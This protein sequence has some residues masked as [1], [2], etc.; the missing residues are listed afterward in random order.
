MS[1]P[2]V[3]TRRFL[4]VWQRNFSV[5]RKT[6][7]ISFVPPLLEPLLY[8]AAFG[9]GLGV[10]VGAVP[11]RGGSVDYLTFIAPGLL[12]VTVMQNAFFE[13]TYASFVR[14]Y[15]QKTFDGMLATPLVLEEVIL[16][17]LAWAATKSLLATTLM[18]AVIA[19][20]G[21]VAF[22]AA[23]LVLPLALLGGVVF[24]AAGML[25][26]A[27]VPNIETFNLP[28]FLFI[29]PMFLFSGTFF[30]VGNLPEWA[31]LLALALPLT[32]LVTLARAATFGFY[33]PHLWGGLAYLLLFAGVGVP[34]A[35]RLMRRRLIR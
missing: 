31:R 21:L 14:M 12:A 16:G 2:P 7:K 27:L 29:T 30:P 22:P 32:H 24:A 6:W 33:D 5:Y 13:T 11:F 3:I 18:L 26:T 8:L 20:F 25:F 35:L 4:R 15:Y 23:L 1:R 19:P 9:V 34:L 10:M 17:E 28:V